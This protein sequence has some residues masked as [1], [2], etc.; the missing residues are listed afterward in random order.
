VTAFFYDPAGT[1]R[2]ENDTLIIQDAIPK[3]TTYRFKIKA[4]SS[5]AEYWGI[6]DFDQDGKTDDNYYSKQRKIR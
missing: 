6:E 4:G 1:W 5:F 2:I 3:R